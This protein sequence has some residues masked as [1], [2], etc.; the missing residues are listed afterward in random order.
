[1]RSPLAGVMANLF[2]KNFE[3][4]ILS[5]LAAKPALWLRYVDDVLILWAESLQ[6][7]SAT[8]IP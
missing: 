7:D 3:K 4:M 6:F 2:M 1:M 5:T 8:Q